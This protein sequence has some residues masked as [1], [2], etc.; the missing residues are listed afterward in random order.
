MTQV[1]VQ[2]APVPLCGYKPR[3][4]R[5][6]ADHG[7]KHR[8]V[9]L[10]FLLNVCQDQAEIERSHAVSPS[11]VEDATPLVD[12]VINLDNPDPVDDRNFFEQ[13]NPTGDQRDFEELPLILDVNFFEPHLGNPT[14]EDVSPLEASVFDWSSSESES[15]N[16]ETTPALSPEPPKVDANSAPVSPVSDR[17]GTPNPFADPC[18]DFHEPHLRYRGVCLSIPHPECHPQGTNL[19][20]RCYFCYLHEGF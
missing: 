14:P 11:L 19:W 20:E 1:S 7:Y 3:G 8:V 5:N 6:Y 13:Q 2:G 12:D 4:S 17:P 10:E 18:E 9:P 15:S 16:T